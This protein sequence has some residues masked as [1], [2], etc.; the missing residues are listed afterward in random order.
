MTREERKTQALAYLKELNIYSPYINGFMKQDKVCY[1]E[2]F[3]GYWVDQQPEVYA[4][5]KDL[6]ARFNATV[7]AITHEYTEFGECYS[8][9][10]VTNYPEE[11]DDLL[12]KEDGTFYVFAYVWNKDVEYFSEFGTIGVKSLGGGITRVA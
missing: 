1:F 12:F 6:E 11:W 7:Y 4:K 8:F 2:R 9:L 3:G 10:M 5:M